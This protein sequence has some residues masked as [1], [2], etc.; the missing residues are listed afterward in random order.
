M[1]RIWIIVAVFL[2]CAGTSYGQV[3]WNIQAGGGVNYFTDIMDGN[4]RRGE[5]YEGGPVFQAGASLSGNL[6]KETITDWEVGLN[7][8]NGG[9]YYVGLNTP[10]PSQPAEWDYANKTMNRDWYIQVPATLSFNFFEGT[11]F[12]T[13]ARLNY[14]FKLPEHISYTYRRWIP[15]GHLGVFTQITPC[16]RIDLTGFIDILPR[17]KLNPLPNGQISGNSSDRRDMG[18]TLNLRYTLK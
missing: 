17:E 11:G 2:W 5:K 12:L 8:I 10:E 1:I 13:G 18:G 15:A 16:I 9:Y 14:R 6:G 3:R 4:A 7:I